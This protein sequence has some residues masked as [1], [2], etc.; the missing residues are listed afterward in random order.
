M[1]APQFSCYSYAFGGALNCYRPHHLPNRYIAALWQ[2]YH[3]P[4]TLYTLR[5]CSSCLLQS[6]E[7]GKRRIMANVAV[8][9]PITVAVKLMPLF[10]FED[11][12]S[13][14]AA[15]GYMS[16]SSRP[17]SSPVGF[18]LWSPY[19]SRLGFQVF[20]TSWTPFY[21]A[22]FLLIFTCQLS[23]LHQ[24]N[25]RL[26]FALLVLD[27]RESTKSSVPKSSHPIIKQ[28]ANFKAGASTKIKKTV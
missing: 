19:K 10:R 24:E 6:D 4:S 22:Y 15:L 1:V 16:Q 20:R 26:L 28:I 27:R 5:G 25:R 13:I 21:E 17:I 18:L 7:M 3:D 12:S 11:P 2:F 9:A 8:Q 14:S 23:F